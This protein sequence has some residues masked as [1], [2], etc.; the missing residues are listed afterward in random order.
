M[1]RLVKIFMYYYPIYIMLIGSLPDRETGRKA[2]RQSDGQIGVYIGKQVG[3]HSND[4]VQVLLGQVMPQ[5][6]ISCGILCLK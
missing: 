2:S 6:E 4:F 5:Q 3:K 1:A